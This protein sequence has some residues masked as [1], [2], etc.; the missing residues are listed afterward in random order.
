MNQSSFAKKWALGNC[1]AID[2]TVS[3]KFGNIDTEFLEKVKEDVFNLS[4]GKTSSEVA[5]P[6]HVTNWTKPMGEAFQYSLFNRSG[7]FDDFSSDHDGTFEGKT[8]K[9][10]E[11]Y[12]YLKSLVDSFPN[13]LNCR[14]NKMGKKGGG[15]SPHEEHIFLNTRWFNISSKMRIRIHIVIETNPSSKMYLRKEE[16]HYSEGGVYGFNN[17]AVHSALNDGDTDR[18]HIVMDCILN[19]E[20]LSFLTDEEKEG[21][22]SR[23]LDECKPIGEFRW[24]NFASYGGMDS[25]YKKIGLRNERVITKLHIG[26]NRIR[27]FLIRSGL[28]KIDLT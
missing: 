24:A 18:F 19:N 3:V 22:F 26:A 14:L 28:V 23:K 9:Q 6:K 16:Y 11:N 8:T 21:F 12:P 10:L 1:N 17:G 7:L 5:N 25:I 13:K 27:A 20:T 15:L 2:G 4:S